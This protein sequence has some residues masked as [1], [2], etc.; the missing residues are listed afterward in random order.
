MA[1]AQVWNDR[2]HE[3]MDYDRPVYAVVDALT[4]LLTCGI[5][6]FAVAKI[7]RVRVFLVLAI[8]R[9]IAVL[10]AIE[11]VHLAFTERPLISFASSEATLAFLKVCSYTGMLVWVVEACA[12]LLLVRWIVQKFVKGVTA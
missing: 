8:T 4:T 1:V 5:W 11:N 10:F 3:A 2:R 9:S 6:W 12:Y 7:S